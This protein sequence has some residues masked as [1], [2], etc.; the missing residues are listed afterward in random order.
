LVVGA[1][2]VTARSRSLQRM[3]CAQHGRVANGVKNPCERTK[4]GNMRLNR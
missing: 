3:V 1:A 4:H 2:D